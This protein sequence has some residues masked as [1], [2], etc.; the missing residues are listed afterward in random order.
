MTKQF[1]TLAEFEEWIH[2]DAFGVRVDSDT[3][4]GI[5]LAPGE[6]MILNLDVVIYGKPR[7]E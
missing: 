3:L 2:A 5:H 7:F 4:Q 1:V 6:E